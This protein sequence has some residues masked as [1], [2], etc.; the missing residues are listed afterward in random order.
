MSGQIVDRAQLKRMSAD[1]I[2]SALA[3]GRL[4]ALID[5][6]DIQR[7][8]KLSP[9][10]WHRALT[11]MSDEEFSRAEADGLLAPLLEDASGPVADADQGA[12]GKRY[13]TLRA[14]LRDLTPDEIYD[15]YTSGAFDSR[16][17]GDT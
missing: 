9:A 13:P 3:D 10:Q 12:R 6:V 2:S 11:N 15:R 8:A 16:L 17:R 7:G 14:E 5:G 4:D 1:E